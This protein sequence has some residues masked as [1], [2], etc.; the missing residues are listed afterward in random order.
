MCVFKG[1]QRN[2]RLNVSVC[3]VRGG[4]KEERGLQVQGKG[5]ERWNGFLLYIKDSSL[6]SLTSVCLPSS[7]VS[8][9]RPV[10]RKKD[11]PP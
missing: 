2:Q 7:E 10:E 6:N 8:P 11:R 9:P 5:S 3:E 4:M 1:R